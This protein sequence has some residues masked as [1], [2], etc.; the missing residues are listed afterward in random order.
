MFFMIWICH[1]S[2]S[3]KMRKEM[4]YRVECN[5]HSLS[6]NRDHSYRSICNFNVCLFFAIPFFLGGD[7]I[8]LMFIVGGNTLCWLMILLIFVIFVIDFCNRRLQQ[9]HTELQNTCTNTFFIFMYLRK[10]LWQLRNVKTLFL[11]GRKKAANISMHTYT[12]LCI[13][14]VFYKKQQ[15]APGPTFWKFPFIAWI[16]WMKSIFSAI[17]QWIFNFS[18]NYFASNK[19]NKIKNVFS[20][21]IRCCHIDIDWFFSTD[22]N[23]FFQPWPNYDNDDNRD[24]CKIMKWRNE[25]H[26]LWRMRHAWH[27]CFGANTTNC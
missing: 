14:V 18:T 8:D 13:Y 22:K 9:S 1:F 4:Q 7:L 15:M 27:K 2:R 26:P 24:E 16:Q 12:K 3:K 21:P 19:W 17:F 25:Y 6:G 20:Q 5:R 10:L 23:D 11:I